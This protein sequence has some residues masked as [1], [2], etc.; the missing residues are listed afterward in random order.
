MKEIELS[1][2]ILKGL[3]EHLE[4]MEERQSQIV[5][6]FIAKNCD[7]YRE[8]TIEFKN[9][10]LQLRQLVEK[11]EELTGKANGMPIITIG[12]LVTVINVGNQK[13]FSFH[14]VGPNYNRKNSRDVSCMS[15]VGRALML[16]QVGDEVLVNAPG[17]T[18]K[19]QVKSIDYIG[20]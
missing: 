4:D 19:Y 2:D 9:Y 14:I 7:E 13:E 11:S 1:P 20:E 15:P 10:L 5:E 6:D 17:G 3:Q 18:F 8:Y 12:T 16:K